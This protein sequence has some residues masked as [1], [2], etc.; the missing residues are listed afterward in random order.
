MGRL[1]EPLDIGETRLRDYVGRRACMLASG[2]C[3]RVV[4]PLLYGLFH[5]GPASSIFKSRPCDVML[6]E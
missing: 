2:M 5:V 4:G 3:I 6:T 1:T